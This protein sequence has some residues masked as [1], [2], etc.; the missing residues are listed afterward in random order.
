MPK[1]PRYQDYVIADGKLVG[2][3]ETMYRDFDD[4]WEQTTR[5][6][7]ASEKA[8]ALN[9]L[10]RLKARNGCRRVLELG[11]GFGDFAAKATALGYDSFGLDISET[12]IAKAKARH[13]QTTFMTGTLSDHG[14]IRDVRP[15]VIVMAE[16]TWYV[17]EQLPDFIAFLKRDLPQT[18]LVHL[19]MTY[20][21]GVQ[22]YGADVFTNLDEIK[23]YFGFDYL[24][25]G[26]VHYDGGARTW[27][28]G[29]PR[30]AQGD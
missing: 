19:L 18:Y 9:L 23:A 22:K 27:F 11:C 10:A 6:E 15:D 2:D 24:E 5:E 14:L 3:F 17:L 16:I 7:F 30:P 26:L 25:S 13:P 8:V 4:P 12:A 20:A 21:P 1:H 28:L 29:K